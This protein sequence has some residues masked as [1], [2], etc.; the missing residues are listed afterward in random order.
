MSNMKRGTWVLVLTIMASV[1]SML[2]AF[3][4]LLAAGLSMNAAAYIVVFI[5]LLPI[6]LVMLGWVFGKFYKG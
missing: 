6:T 3:P 2:I 4:I 5:V 1:I